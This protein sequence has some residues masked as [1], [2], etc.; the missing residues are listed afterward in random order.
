MSIWV[1]VLGAVAIAG[2]P[3]AAVQAEVL[4]GLTSLNT[5][6]TFETDDASIILTSAPITGIG[7]GETLLDIDLRPGNVRL[8]TLSSAGTLYMLT[9]GAAG[10]AATSVGA[11]GAS[12]T[13][14]RHGI[15][16]NP[17]ADRLRIVSNSNQSLRVNPL[18]AATAVD[19]PVSFLASPA[20]DPNIVGVAY[21]NNRPDAVT[22]ILYGL[23][24]RTNTLVR[25]VSPN[26][27]VLQTVGA[28]SFNAGTA[29]RVGFDISGATG[30]AFA[31]RNNRLYAINLAT[32]QSIRMGLIGGP[33][34]AE[35]I[36][37]TAATVPEPTSW[38]LMIGGFG[39][40]G[41][42]LRRRRMLAA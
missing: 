36:G 17:A 21:T 34:G 25:F 38:V 28:L 32:G 24:A 3:L 11:L 13:G 15:D 41:A 16:F 33:R 40:V 2:A 30:D 22:T 5:I 9:G 14:S 4:F 27:G 7:A 12:L 26:T 10:Y 1:R 8:Y 39:A 35:I 20:T 19:A 31:T 42:S 6:V 29:A 23:D 18:S 37:I